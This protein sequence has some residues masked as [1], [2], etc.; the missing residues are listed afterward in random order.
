VPTPAVL[1]IEGVAKNYAWGSRTAIPR[2]LGVEPGEDPVAELWFGA[3]LAEA[4]PALGHGGLDRLIAADPDGLLGSA[5]VTRFGPRLPFLV[6]ILA[7]DHA[8]SIQAHPNLEQARSGFAAEDARGIP[9]DA[10]ERNYR[11]ANHKPELLCAVTRFEALCG[12][13]P[14]AETL[15]LLDELDLPELATVR[16]LLAGPDGL[17]DA[18]THLLT[19]LDAT[20]VLDAVVRRVAAIPDGSEWAG[21]ARAVTLAAADFPGDVG[22]VLALLLNHVVLEPGEAIYLAAGNVHSYLRGTGIEV[23]ANS[24]NVLRCGL[25]PKHVDV[26]ELLKVTDFRPLIEPRWTP[27]AGASGLEFEVPVPDFALSVIDLDA[28][29]GPVTVG[30]ASPYIV[31]CTEGHASVGPIEASVE[32]TPGHAAFVGARAVGFEARGAGRVFAATVGTARASAHGAQGDGVSL[33]P[34]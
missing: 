9:R 5:S 20:P 15:R 12:F 3:H 7:A 26:A 2:L 17:R 4:S 18:F 32:L 16:G 13:R 24:D 22:A 21:V 28:Y 25:T 30:D 33:A 8:L 6:K 34:K 14:I 23:M 19:L 29:A 1:A 11:D 31:L 10:P 27:T